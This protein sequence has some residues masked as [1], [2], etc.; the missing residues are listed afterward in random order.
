MQ[1]LIE[2]NMCIVLITIMYQL[3]DTNMFLRMGFLTYKI[4]NPIVN[5]I[6]FFRPK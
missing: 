2:E 5:V 6:I 3:I 4:Y 1:T